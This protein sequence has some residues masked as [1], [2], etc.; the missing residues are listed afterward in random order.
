M[1]GRAVSRIPGFDDWSYGVFRQ[2]SGAKTITVPVVRDDGESV[3]FTV[4]EF[5]EDP[6]DLREVAGI[7]IRAMQKWD[8]VQGLGA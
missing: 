5:V 2:D 6:E 3:E 7:V 4:P 8:A 1:A